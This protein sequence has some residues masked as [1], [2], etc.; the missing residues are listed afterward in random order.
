MELLKNQVHH[1]CESKSKT[2]NTLRIILILIVFVL[3]FMQEVSVL[4]CGAINHF[5]PSFYF[6]CT[7]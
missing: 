2:R 7:K 6:H 5:K 4:V 3:P 1:Q